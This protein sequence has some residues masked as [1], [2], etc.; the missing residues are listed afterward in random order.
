M[1]ILSHFGKNNGVVTVLFWKKMY[2]ICQTE[3]KM[4]IKD[5]FH[6][7]NFWFSEHWLILAFIIS[8]IA[9]FLPGNVKGVF[10]ALF[11]FFKKVVFKI[12]I[13]LKKKSL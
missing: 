7:F 3:P 8:E 13:H 1:K 6:Y 4:N 5:A 10:H 11:V 9:A 12:I 2:N